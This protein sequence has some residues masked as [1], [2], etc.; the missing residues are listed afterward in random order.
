MTTKLIARVVRVLQPDIH[1]VGRIVDGKVV[2]VADL[3]LPSR[4]II[5]L[6]GGRQEPCMMFRY[7]DAD[8]FCG[9]TWHETFDNA[10]SQA[11]YEYGLSESEFT[12]LEE[13]S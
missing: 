8:V 3:P 11:S 6:D 1:K 9:D 4:V 10:L 5:E 2:P 13:P 7:T 12:E